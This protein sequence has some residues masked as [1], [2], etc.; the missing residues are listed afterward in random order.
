MEIAMLLTDKIVVKNRPKLKLCDCGCGG[1]P[2]GADYL[3]GH[4]ESAISAI[5]KH[6]GGLRNLREIVELYTG[7]SVIVDFCI[8]KRRHS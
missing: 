2:R 5:V 1:Y 8:D 4:E 7:K 3:P 6:V